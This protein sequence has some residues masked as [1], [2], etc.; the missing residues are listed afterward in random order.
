MVLNGLL[1]LILAALAAGTGFSALLPS[2]GAF[3]D[4]PWTLDVFSKTWELKLAALFWSGGIVLGLAGWTESFRIFLFGHDRSAEIGPLCFG[5]SLAGFSLFV[6]GL[7]VS[8][9]FFSPLVVIFFFVRVPAG[10]RLLSGPWFHSWTPAQKGLLL[11]GL[12]PWFFEYASPP[13]LFDAVLDHFRFAEEVARL[14]QIPFHWINHTGDI[15]KGA[16][17]IWAGFW[18]LGGETLAHLLSA[19]PFAGLIYLGMSLARRL[20]L[21]EWPGVFIL[22]ACPF[23]MALF[24]WGYDEGLLAFYEVLALVGLM[25]GFGKNK[26]PAGLGLCFFFLGAALGVKYTALFAWAGITAVF[27]YQTFFEKDRVRFDLRWVLFALIPCLPWLSRDALANG[28]PFYPMASAWFGGPPG[29]NS[30][31]EA[32]LWQDTGRGSAGLTWMGA[33]KTLWVDFGTGRNQVGAVLSPLLLMAVPLWGRLRKFST[34][35]FLFLFAVVFFGGWIVFCTNLRHA[36]GGLLALALLSGL[37][38]ASVFKSSPKLLRWV[39]GLGL[40]VSFWMVWVAQINTTLPYG[41]AL[42]FQDPLTRLKR[43][44]VMDFDTFSA[45]EAI[46]KSSAAVDKSMAFAVYQTYPLRRTAFVDFFWKQPIF[47]NWV[48][49]CQT[50]G[51]LAEKLKRE[52]VVCFLYQRSESAFM[53]KKEKDFHWSGMPIDEYTRFWEYYTEPIE[54]F[55]NSSVYRILA[56]PL[57]EPRKLTDLPGLEEAEGAALFADQQKGQ[58]QAAYQTAADLTRQRP[59]IGFGWERR[60]YYAGRLGDWKEAVKSG[61]RAEGLGSETLDLCD[62]MTLSWVQLGQPKLAVSWNEK[63]EARSRWLEGLKLE[64]LSFEEE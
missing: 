14:H 7:G 53:S 11:A 26:S 44:Y 36:A 60:A 31:L 40:I 33:L 30:S 16:E 1:F 46:E 15:P 32:D 61:D 4:I 34:A 2:L 58:W 55:E 63:R 62:T 10:M 6:F 42:G 49:Q 47:F 37:A 29:Y 24:S 35:R 57:P 51:Q 38:W 45:Y 50:A 20:Q 21:P 43:N 3:F 12:L 9:I 48:S 27:I 22:V 5:I 56:T 28:N 25:I 8:G 13:I 52:G 17:L 23:W 41:C 59:E 64:S 18:A 54:I 39:F 19:L